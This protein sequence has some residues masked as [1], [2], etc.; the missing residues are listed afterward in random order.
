MLMG[1][2]YIMERGDNDMPSIS[3]FYG[4]IVYMYTSDNEK[5]H[6]P[7]IHIR[8]SGKKATFSIENGELINGEVPNKIMKLVKAWIEIH[9]DELMANWELAINNGEIYKIEPLK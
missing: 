9:Y 3:M 2:D 5:H 7:H 6:T 4:I 1:G 8:Y